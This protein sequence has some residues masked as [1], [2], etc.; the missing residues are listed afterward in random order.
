MMK[1]DDDDHG[2]VELL[3]NAGAGVDVETIAGMSPRSLAE[4]VEPRPQETPSA[5]SPGANRSE[6]ALMA[7]RAIALNHA[8]SC[9]L[10]VR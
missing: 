7:A 9:I 5:K 3:L 10:T 4:R 1:I 8:G 6:A 2:V